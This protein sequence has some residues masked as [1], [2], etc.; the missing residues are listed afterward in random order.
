MMVIKS[1][2]RA[3]RSS[4][5][6]VT[7]L[8]GSG[9]PELSAQDV[10]LRPQASLYLPTRIS[11]QH[12]VLQVGQRVGVT[13]GARLTIVF[14]ER[15]DLVTRVTYI[16]GYLAFRGAGT[17]IHIGTRSHLLAATMGTRYWVLQPV[18]KLSWEIHSGLGAAFGGP[19]AYE[20]LFESSTVSGVLGT[21]VHYQIG[22]AVRLQLRVEDRIYRVRLGAGNLGRSGPPLRVSFGL[23]LP[24]V[25]SARAAGS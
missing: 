16:P 22:R 9:N 6:V 2:L 24:F 11:R 1:R 3:A 13:V 25:D 21:T 23:T 19:Y 12:G 20:D 17:L 10:Q 4:A 15:L 7:A 5:F 8:L 14:N 18:R